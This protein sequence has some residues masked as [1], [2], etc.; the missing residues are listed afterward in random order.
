MKTREHCF[1]VIRDIDTLKHG[2]YL[3]YFII[4]SFSRNDV[5]N[6]NEGIYMKLFLNNIFQWS[7]ITDKRLNAIA[8]PPF[9]YKE[10]LLNY[11]PTTIWYSER[12]R[13]M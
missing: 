7:F 13:N 2:L 4:K 3:T 8:P 11:N 10:W 1:C 6:A 9:L 12:G 5:V